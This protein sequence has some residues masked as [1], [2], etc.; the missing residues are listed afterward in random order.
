MVKQQIEMF[1]IQFNWYPRILKRKEPYGPVLEYAFNH[2][3]SYFR[4]H[5]QTKNRVQKYDLRS[6]YI[7]SVEGTIKNKWFFHQAFASFQEAYEYVEKQIKKNRMRI[8]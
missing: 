3:E 2:R 4:I 1:D 7:W 5:L 8:F 6:T